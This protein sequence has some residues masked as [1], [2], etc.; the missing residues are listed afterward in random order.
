[1]ENN[2][3]THRQLQHWVADRLRAAILDGQFKPGEWLRQERLAQELGVS[4]MPIREAL[5]ELAAEGMVEHLPYRG[6]RVLSFS[7][8]DVDDL[9]AHR[10]FLEGRAARA[11]ALHISPEELAELKS[12]HSQMVAILGPEQI[13]A[14][15][16]LNRRF[17]QVIY[18]ASRHE[19]LIRTLQQMWSAFPNMLLGN[20]ARTATSP[21]PQR[22]DNDVREH[23][24]II[25]A[26][27]SHDPDQ[28]ERCTQEHIEYSHKQ[29]VAEIQSKP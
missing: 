17:H 1:M 20:F 8:E 22:E 15:R 28:A 14:Y 4:Q 11:A 19:Y 13:N 21:L 26:L 25:A 5:K 10:S 29:L 12:L 3:F 2:S 7:R 9:Y 6:V 27:E 24:R 23:A 18:T 16:A